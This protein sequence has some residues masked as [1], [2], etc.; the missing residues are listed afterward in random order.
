MNIY[1]ILLNNT[2]NSNKIKKCGTVIICHFHVLCNAGNL[3]REKFL[4]EIKT[5]FCDKAKIQLHFATIIS[6][7]FEAQSAKDKM[8]R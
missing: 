3:K 4:C 7:M 1:I 6:N 8:L 2:I 5:Y